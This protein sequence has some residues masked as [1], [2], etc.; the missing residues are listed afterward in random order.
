[1]ATANE[2]LAKLNNSKEGNVLLIDNDLRTISIPDSVKSLGV[3]FDDD[4]H[5][6]NFQM[7]RMYGTTDLSKFNIRINYM[8]ANDEGDIYVVT[9]KNVLEASI[10]FSW[11]VGA[12]ALAYKGDVRFI[13]CLKESNSDGDVLREFNTTVTTL[14]V[15]E[16]LEVDAAPLESELS[17]VL[18]Q[19]L[20]LTVAKVAEVTAAGAEQIVKVQAKSTEEQNNIA[21]KGKEVLA[22]IPDDYQSTTKLADEG[23]RTKADAIICSAEGETIILHDSSDDYVRGLK[24]LGKTTQIKTTGVQKLPY[25]YTQGSRTT[26]G[27]TY[28][29]NNDGSITISGTSTAKAYLDL[30][31]G[32]SP[33]IPGPHFLSG[34]P[35]DSGFKMYA[36]TG[37]AYKEDN[38]NGALLADGVTSVHIVVDS[39]VTVNTT[40]YPMLNEGTSALPWEPYTGGIPG[41]NPE[42]PQPLVSAGASGIINTIAS[43]KNLLS[44]DYYKN[45]SVTTNGVTVTVNDDG[46]ITW[47]G[48]ATGYVAVELYR[49]SPSML[50]KEFTV[51]PLGTFNNVGIQVDIMLNN[52]SL[53]STNVRSPR[54]FDMADYPT[55]NRVILTMKRVTNGEVTGTIYP[56][57]VFG[58]VIST[59][60]E[61]PTAKIVTVHTP[62]G[63]P[64]IPVTSGGNYTDSDGQQ[65]IC[66]EIDFERGVYIQRILKLTLTGNETVSRENTTSWATGCYVVY[67]KT[68][69]PE[70][71]HGEIMCS[72]LPPHS[73]AD[74]AD[75]KYAY[76]IG[77]HGQP[78]LM[79]KFSDEINTL[80]LFRTAWA[81]V[82]GDG[83]K[84]H[85]ILITPIETALTADELVAFQALNTNRLNTI[86]LNDAGAWMNLHY[87]ADTETWINN[88]IDE[89]IAA[90]V[91][92]L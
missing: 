45:A 51:L 79:V 15:L 44:F 86:V 73:N 50:P 46:S 25:P 75:G 17:D 12:H 81:K 83:G 49:G 47:T 58:N 20:S 67:T 31:N 87:N 57:V 27:I 37:G 56:M 88:L 4:V 52:T 55:A 53:Y 78:N 63:L 80:E 24:I 89:K 26:N 16:G 9:D 39:D 48:T 36:Y 74:L 41:P 91:A 19:L 32:P 76:G 66:D 84:V 33:E 61:S 3:E 13:V 38:G 29:V 11:L 92:K 22:T 70:H 68:N 7:P 18:E 82:I 14:P 28:T 60:Y 21:K 40:I 30:Y 77:T 62:N 35:K 85:V 43:G 42:Y 69:N 71:V 2:L 6:L 5:R 64:G 10:T 54:Y 8:N 90:A 1:M 23:V 34:T 72:F 59:D 65:W